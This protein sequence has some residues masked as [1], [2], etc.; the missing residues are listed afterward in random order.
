MILICGIPSEPAI[1]KV[2]EQLNK[3]GAPHIMFNQRRFTSTE[4]EFKIS[5][6]QITGFMRLEGSTFRLK[7]F[8]GVYTRL[9]DFRYLP[10]LRGDPLNSPKR[11]HC[12][13]LHE[14][15]MH[16]F[17]IAQA[18]VVSR[19]SILGSNFSKPYQAQLIQKQGFEVPETL[20]TNDPDL[21]FQFYKNHNRVI[22]KSISSVRSIVQTLKDN[23][24]E[25][26]NHIRWCPTQFQNYIE[27]SNVR[28]HV[29]GK[30]VFATAVNTDATDYRYAYQVGGQTELEAIEL[31]D[32]LAEKC[33]KLSHALGLEVSGIDLKITSDN[34]VFCF[35]V[36]PSPAFTYYENITE[37]P[38][39]LAIARHLVNV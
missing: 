4:L 16:W 12:R 19:P 17:Q 5:K 27:G 22:Y 32:Q 21:V 7:D 1:T 26:L 25:R 6:G 10:E 28:V 36:N 38:I 15:L 8:Q 9:M 34:K 13:A 35:E 2:R 23:D 31:T 11:M 3:I 18:R 37:Q 39:A 20:I 30:E 14:T 29:V 24:F 33:I